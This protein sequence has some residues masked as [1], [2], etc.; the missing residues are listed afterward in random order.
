MYARISAL[1]KEEN[2]AQKKY[3]LWEL[4]CTELFQQGQKIKS[5]EEKVALYFDG[6]LEIC[7]EGESLLNRIE[8]KVQSNIS[9]I[10]VLISKIKIS[11]DLSVADSIF[12]YI[13]VF[14]EEDE[15]IEGLGFVHQ[16]D[17]HFQPLAKDLGRKGKI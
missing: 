17:V 13:N 7:S 5:I 4:K 12:N 6:P 10:E 8:A 16:E 11:E 2:D 1:I 15:D 3:R 9:S 14:I